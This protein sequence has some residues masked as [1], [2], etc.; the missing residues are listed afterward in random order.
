MDSSL[1]FTEIPNAPHITL[2]AG[3][4]QWAD[5]GS[6][7]SM[8]P[9]YLIEELGARKIG[10]FGPGG[11]Y[12]FQVPGA[13]HLMRPLIELEDGLP[14]SLD[15]PRN[16]F[17][18]AGTDEQGV[19]IFIG[20]EPHLNVAEYAETFLAGVEQLNISLVAGVAGVYGPVPY[21]KERQVSCVYSLPAM[22]EQLEAYALEFSNYSGG[23]SIGTYLVTKAGERDLSMFVLYAFAPAYDFP[24]EDEISQGIRLEN[25]YRSWYDI[26]RRLNRLLQIKVDLTDLEERS[27]ELE[28]V[29]DKR[30]GELEEEMPELGIR[31]VLEAIEGGFSE[32]PYVPLD[33]LWEEEFRNLF[34]DSE[35]DVA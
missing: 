24:G 27:V 6:V 23:S 17:Y 20:D 13:H 8:L 5:A 7:S 10:E 31:E 28:Q 11:Y 35:D 12:M 32:T 22:R 3:W 15:E 1:R 4:R 19:V 18:Y 33:D 14:K 29:I 30:I 21:N 26:M 2:I 9:E 34:G 25:D 16:E